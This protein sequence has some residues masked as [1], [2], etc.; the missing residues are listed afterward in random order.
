METFDT[1]MDQVDEMFMMTQSDPQTLS[2]LYLDQ[3]KEDPYSRWF[4]YDVTRNH[5]KYY[6]SY[7]KYNVSLLDNSRGARWA[8][9][10]AVMAMIDQLIADGGINIVSVG[11]YRDDP[12]YINSE[13]I[14]IV[15]GYDDETYDLKLTG[16]DDSK[17]EYLDLRIE[18]ARNVERAL[19][20]FRLTNQSYPLL[21]HVHLQF[22]RKMDIE[23]TLSGP[24]IK[25]LSVDNGLLPAHDRDIYLRLFVD[26]NIQLDYLNAHWHSK[27]I[28]NIHHQGRE[29]YIERLVNRH[30][31]YID[32]HTMSTTMIDIIRRLFGYDSPAAIQRRDPQEWPRLTHLG[33]RYLLTYY[34]PVQISTDTTDTLAA[35]KDYMKFLPQLTSLDVPLFNSH[36]PIVNKLADKLVCL[37]LNY[38]NR[39]ANK[40]VLPTR[41][42]HIRTL[43]L[44]LPNTYTNVSIG[45]WN[46]SKTCSLLSI[47][48]L[49][50]RRQFNNN[51]HLITFVNLKYVICRYF[52]DIE[53]SLLSGA[54][55]RDVV[56][57]IVDYPASRSKI[58]SPP[59]YTVVWRKSNIYN[60]PL[61]EL[62][63]LFKE[64]Q[65]Q[66]NYNSIAYLKGLILEEYRDTISE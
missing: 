48:F 23:V 22:E 6:R 31:R 19:I 63:E 15:A 56:T 28:L 24:R 1:L 50:P 21:T 32:I 17:L 7:Q 34:E 61:E 53:D 62:V 12:I 30:T 45:R 20:V 29:H 65:P 57:S 52:D 27:K 25:Y 55:L 43:H 47:Y 4:A 51:F 64:V 35:T 33:F 8:F 2:Q 16:G 41:L 11:A 39:D 58:L 5:L 37:G 18:T 36:V 60:M 13:S 40:I 42:K 3:I 9:Y 46:L 49:L 26:D 66:N 38:I 54:L 59:D 10:P 14:G 44:Y